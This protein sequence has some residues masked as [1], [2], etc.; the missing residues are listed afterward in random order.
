MSQ[1]ERSFVIISQA[2]AVRLELPTKPSWPG[3]RSGSAGLVWPTT[4]KQQTA[5]AC[6]RTLACGCNGGRQRLAS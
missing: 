6:L 1:L 4:G 3:E 5:L 2:E